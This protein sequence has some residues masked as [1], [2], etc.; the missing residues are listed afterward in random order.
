[1]ISSPFVFCSLAPKR[2]KPR[3]VKYDDE[4]PSTFTVRSN[5]ISSAPKVEG[6]QSVKTDTSTPKPE[7]ARSAAVENGTVS[8]DMMSSDASEQQ[9]QP[10]TLKPERNLVPV[11]ESKGATAESESRGDVGVTKEEPQSPKKESASSL[12]LDDDRRQNLTVTKG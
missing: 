10:D 9:S 2:K 5:P 6:D 3:P 12:R 11:V 1:M 7:K 4:N 8:Y